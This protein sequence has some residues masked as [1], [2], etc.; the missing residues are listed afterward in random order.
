MA[1]REIVV[2]AESH[3]LYR[4]LTC[5]TVSDIQTLPNTPDK[6]A[7]GA[8]CFV[9]EDSSVWCLDSNFVWKEV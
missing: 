1:F 2:G 6:I 7:W 8:F 3:N 9:I 5:D 4:E